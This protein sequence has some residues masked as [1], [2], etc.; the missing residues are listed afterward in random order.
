MCISFLEDQEKDN[1]FK[2]FSEKEKNNF[3]HNKLVFVFIGGRDL[4]FVSFSFSFFLLVYLF[5]CLFFICFFW[6]DCCCCCLGGYFL[7]LLFF[8]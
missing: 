5:V 6:G 7:L 8:C 3:E 4:V 2:K 1:N